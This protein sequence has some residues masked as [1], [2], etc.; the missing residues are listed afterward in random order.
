MHGKFSQT[1]IFSLYIY[2]DISIIVSHLSK[3]YK[4]ALVQGPNV[5]AAIVAFAFEFRT[6]AMMYLVIV[7]N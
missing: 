5:G 4:Y 7:E 2:N 3:V 1:S 6:S